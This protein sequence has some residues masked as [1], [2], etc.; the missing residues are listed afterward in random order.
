MAPAVGC[1]HDTNPKAVIVT[2]DGGPTELRLAALADE[3]SEVAGALSTAFAPGSAVLLLFAGDE[4]HPLPANQTGQAIDVIYASPL[5]TIVD[6]TGGVAVGET[7]PE[8]RA[9]WQTAVLI[10]AGLA[11]RLG[12]AIGDKVDPRNV[13][14]PLLPP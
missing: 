8:S 12:V 6:F 1:F 9:P 4:K 13:D 2:R 3:E 10:E 5:K 11:E 7:P 14:S